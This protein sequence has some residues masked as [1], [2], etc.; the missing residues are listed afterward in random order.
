MQEETA[1]TL[2]KF[3]PRSEVSIDLDIVCL[4]CRGAAT[5]I[6]RCAWAYIGCCES[7]HCRDY[8]AKQAVEIANIVD[9]Y[10]EREGIEYLG[11][12]ILLTPSQQ[13]LPWWCALKKL[14]KKYLP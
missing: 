4:C 13:T 9:S 12:V 6:A 5:W 1:V 7:Q 11:Q 14:I 10:K 3:V 8:A 2:I